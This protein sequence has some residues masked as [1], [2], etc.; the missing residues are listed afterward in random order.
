MTPRERILVSVAPVRVAPERS[1]DTNIAF[2]KLARLRVEP[3]SDTF[4]K[5]APERSAP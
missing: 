5:S 3:Y 1:V 2:V 4:V